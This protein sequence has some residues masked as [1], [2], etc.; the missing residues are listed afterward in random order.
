MNSFNKYLLNIY[1]EELTV[2]R[3]ENTQLLKKG[4]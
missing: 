2:Q 4:L 3:T 1:Q